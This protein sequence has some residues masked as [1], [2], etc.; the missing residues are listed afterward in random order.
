MQARFM[1]AWLI[2]SGLSVAL[3]AG[4]VGAAQAAPSVAEALEL[5]PIQDGVDYDRA[6]AAKTEDYRISAEKRNGATAWVVRNPDGEIVREFADVNGNNVVDQWSYDKD[7]VEVYRDIDGDHNGKADQYRW[8]HSGGLRWGI[9]G[10]ED[11]IIESWKMISP[12]EVAEEAITAVRLKDTRRFQRLLMDQKEIASLGIGKSRRD[13]LAKSVRNAVGEL[14]RRS[15]QQK[16]VNRNTKFVDFGGRR[17]SIVP[18]GTDGS[19]RDIV[20]YEDIS[21]LVETDGKH[22]QVYLGAMVRVGDSWKLTSAPDFEAPNESN[23]IGFSRPRTASTVA[24]LAST[25]AGAPNEEMQKMLAELEQ[26]DVQASKASPAQQAGIVKKRTRLLEKLASMATNPE[27]RAQWTRQLADM[28]SAAVQSGESPTALQDLERLEERLRKGNA[29][30]ALLAHVE[31]RRMS[32]AYGKSLQ[33]PQADFVKIQSNW[34]SSLESFAKR[35][36]R[37]PEA[38]E[39]MLQLAMAKEFAG[40]FE[41]AQQWYREIVKLAPQ[42]PN[43]KKSAGAVRRLNSVGKPLQLRGPDVRGRKVDI[44]SLRGKHV[45]VQYWATWCEPCKADL[46]RLKELYA[47]YGARGFAIVGVSLDNTADD[48]KRY[49][50]SNRVP[51][52][53]IFESG[54]LDSRLANEMGVMT[55]PLMLLVDPQGRVINRGIHVAELDT[56][57]QKRLKA[58]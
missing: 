13:E 48:L 55:L 12:E 27:G 23:H 30:E 41:D 57:L 5:K 9:D 17:P 50:Q 22:E 11:G 8:F 31:F 7:G 58:R 18:A 21:A 53:Q 47:K 26:L 36:A 16:I 38:S 34:L 10:D 25:T 2:P 28:L 52:P 33:Q 44:A 40:E 14:K 35:Y 56:E 1:T 19:T 24:S 51:W 49:L 20:V 15:G 42:S 37:T 39:A 32:A 54:G 3:L 46:A 4:H 29:S 43:A 45:L 6:D